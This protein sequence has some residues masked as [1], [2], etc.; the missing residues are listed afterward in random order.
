MLAGREPARCLR[1]P[2]GLSAAAPS[3]ATLTCPGLAVVCRCV[4]TA[5]HRAVVAFTSHGAASTR[6]TR[7]PPRTVE[8][9]TAGRRS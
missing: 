5:F 7:G 2:A 1:G 8:T 3:M 9:Y 6:T 4:S